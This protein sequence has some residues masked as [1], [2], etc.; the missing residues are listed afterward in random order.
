MICPNNIFF[1][2]DADSIIGSGHVI[3]CEIIADT[4]REKQ[5]SLNIYFIC[6]SIPE[7]F[8]ERLRSKGYEIIILNDDLDKEFDEQK[9]ILSQYPSSILII[10]S[11]IGLYYTKEYQ[12]GIKAIVDRLAIITF[13]N[14]CHFFADIVH[15]Q[16]I[17]AKHSDYSVEPHTKLLLGSEYVILNKRFRQLA[18]EKNNKN[19][20]GYDL[21]IL[22]SF[23]GADEPNRTKT[24]IEALSLLN[25]RISK[26]VIVLGALYTQREELEQLIKNCHI[27]TVLYQ[28]TD[29]MPELMFDSDLAITS[30]GLTSWELGVLRVPNIIIPHSKREILS[31]RYLGENKYAFV[32]YDFLKKNKKDIASYLNKVLNSDYDFRVENLSNELNE[33]GIDKFVEILLNN[34]EQYGKKRS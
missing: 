5:K 31:A 28:N 17:M 10:D 13:Y 23:G 6:R 15:N 26:I 1:R 21:N 19:Q 7:G 11:D 14:D 24:I 29:K 8:G 32:I 20:T 27:Q 9:S 33:D 3:R 22:L 18:K 25:N 12:L 34:E 4:I 30:G 2:V 16:N